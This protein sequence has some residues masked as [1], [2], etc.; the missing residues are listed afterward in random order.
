MRTEKSN[1]NQARTAGS[2]KHFSL[3]NV[4]VSFGLGCCECDKMCCTLSSQI[5][6]VGVSRQM[7]ENK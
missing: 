2:G 5:N 1:Q 4:K 6:M 7:K 3:G